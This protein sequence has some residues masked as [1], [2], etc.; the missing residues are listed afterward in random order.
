MTAMP[1]PEP[2]QRRKSS[3]ELVQEQLANLTEERIAENILKIKRT[4]GLYERIY[5]MS[6]NEMRRM[7]AAGE[8]EETYD[9]CCWSQ[10]VSLLEDVLKD[11]R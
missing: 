2:P 10:E 9:I 1:K 3:Y 4:I 6:S 11:Q 7:V 8:I 5:G